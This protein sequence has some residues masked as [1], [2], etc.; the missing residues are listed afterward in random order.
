MAVSR[1]ARLYL[2]R[3]GL[4]ILR[5]APVPRLAVQDLSIHKI[6]LDTEVAPLQAI[7][8]DLE[9]VPKRDRAEA[10]PWPGQ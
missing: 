1:S 5:P 9:G 10:R 8:L 3:A 7:L 6:P 2:E 4:N